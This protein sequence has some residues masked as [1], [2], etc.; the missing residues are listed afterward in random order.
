MRSAFRST[1]GTALIQV[2]V[3]WS[4]VTCAAASSPVSIDGT[5]VECEVTGSMEPLLHALAAAGVTRLTT[6]EPSLEELFVSHY[7]TGTSA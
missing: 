1:E 7:G 6:R 5:S 3:R 2:G 4:I